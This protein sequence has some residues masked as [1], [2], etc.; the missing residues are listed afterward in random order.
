MKPNPKFVLTASILTAMIFS[1]T[2]VFAA[3]PPKKGTGTAKK[4]PVVKK[5]APV[6]D[7][8]AVVPPVV[9]T[10]P[11]VPVVPVNLPEI[12][13]VV[14]G[15]E[16][17][18]ADL[19]QA[20]ARMLSAQGIPGDKLPAEQRM[21]GYRMI[22][23]DMIVEKII[24]KRSAGVEVT[25]KDV[26]AKMEEFKVRFGSD[27]KLKEQI[28]KSGLT[29]E[30][31]KENIREG[32]RQEKWIDE[33]IKGLTEVTDAEVEDFYKK[34]PDQFKQ[35]EQVRA[36]HILVAVAKDAKPD[37]VA[38]KQKAATAIVARVKKGE[39]FDKLAKELSEDPSAKQ[40][41]GD[42]NFFGREQMVPEFSAAAFK[43]KKDE[44][45]DP[46][47]SQFGFHVIKVTD[48]KDAETVSLETAKP[49]LAPYLKQQKRQAEIQKA[50]KALR[51]KAEVK[52]NLPEAPKAA[53][54][55]ALES[56]SDPKAAP[57]PTDAA[58]A[59]AAP[60]PTDAAPAKAAPAPTDAAP[61]KAAPAPADAA[62]AKAAP[63]P[64]DAAPA[65]AAPAPAVAPAP[66][67]TAPAPGKLNK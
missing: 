48:H 25:D 19:E 31:V 11:V 10:A 24:T 33:Q 4:V 67:P 61:A 35:P 18:K 21:Q 47:R 39:A 14:E 52:N 55:P 60:A 23:D 28:E 51:A 30:K 16:I 37:V 49:K 45:S 36:S 62:P 57:A 6:K 40:N 38:A 54:G 5:D 46:V 42:L 15:L 26:A 13:A 59:K 2:S 65:K 27:E 64:A 8:A 3:D 41:G 58:P 29:V 20:F 53:G 43:M 32:L 63:A 22:L 17:K 44:I 7:D 1:G 9:E 12:V 66:V 34:N 50:V 56:P